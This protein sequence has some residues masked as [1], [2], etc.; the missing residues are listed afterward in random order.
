MATNVETLTNARDN[1]PNTYTDI[2]VREIDFVTRFA[3]NWNALREIMGITRSI[4]KAPGSVLKSYTAT[5]TLEDGDV[6]AGAV[7]PYSKATVKETTFG[8]LSLRKYAKAVPIE[9]VEAYG[10]EIAVQRTDE[11]FLNELQ[12]IV[13]DDFY[14]ALTTNKSAMKETVTTFQMAVAL[15]VGKVQDKFK[16][17]RRDVTNI[18]V[19]VNTLDAYTYLGAAE[20]TVQTQNGMNYLE[21][22]LGA[23][24]V[25]LSS[26]IERG[27]VIGIPADNII[28]YHINPNTQYGA[29]GLTYTTDGVTNLIGFHANGNYTTAVG[30]SFAL[31]GLTL[32]LEFADGVAIMT[33][34]PTY[35][36]EDE[37]NP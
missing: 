29:L 28:D 17:L 36:P 13:M 6:P 37:E 15:A 32:W 34:D 2:T 5:V 25:I 11:A 1:L 7:I 31:M 30:E 24:T 21:N 16:K 33:V 4:E 18:V 3:K 27:T 9:D 35:T 12:G 14:G 10:A 23:R 19:F 8:E 26:E 22:F 20:L